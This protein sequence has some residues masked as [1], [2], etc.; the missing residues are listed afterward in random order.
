MG[1]D[2]FRNAGHS[3]PAG[4][5]T[6]M[7]DRISSLMAATGS[8][9]ATHGLG[10]AQVLDFDLVALRPPM[11]CQHF[12]HQATMTPVRFSLRAKKRHFSFKGG[13]IHVIQ[14]SPLH[15]QFPKRLLELRPVARLA[16]GSPNLRAGSEDGLIVIGD[17]QDSI[18]E[19][20]KVGILR[21]S[22]ELSDA[23]LPDVNQL[24]HSGL[25]KKPEE[26]LRGLLGEADGENR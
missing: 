17:S 19:E 24:L 7:S 3:R 22:G 5:I 21:K 6:V 8:F 16:V 26:F 12:R 9:F 18:K 11:L 4:P 25:A 2:P 13:R 10:G 14:N 23:V 1:W 20:G 15:H